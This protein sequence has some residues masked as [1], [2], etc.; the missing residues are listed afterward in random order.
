[1]NFVSFF[2]R[3]MTN[4]AANSTQV[5]PHSAQDAFSKININKVPMKKRN[6][7]KQFGFV[8]RIRLCFNPL[9]TKTI[10]KTNEKKMKVQV[11]HNFFI[12]SRC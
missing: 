11:A 1:M 8:S 2:P 9:K 6:L 7:Y 3:K 5:C 4:I 10:F 12:L